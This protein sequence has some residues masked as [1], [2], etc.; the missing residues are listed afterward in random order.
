MRKKN[1]DSVKGFG[2]LGF[3]YFQKIEAQLVL[4]AGFKP[5]QVVN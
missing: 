4:P 1:T 2:K 5:E 3:K